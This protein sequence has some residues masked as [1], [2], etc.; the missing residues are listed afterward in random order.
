MLP[1]DN[2]N[3]GTV[4]VKLGRTLLRERRYREAESELVAGSEILS[5]QPGG[6]GE[7]TR[8]ARDDLALVNQALGEHEKD[9]RVRPELAVAH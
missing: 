2:I 3:T 7:W 9:K 4:R 1:A 6:S 5:R 8:S